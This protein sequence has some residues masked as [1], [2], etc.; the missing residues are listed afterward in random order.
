MELSRRRIQG[1]ISQKQGTSTVIN[2]EGG[3]VTLGPLLTSL[4]AEAMP[5]AEGYLHWTGSAWEWNSVVAESYNSTTAVR[6]KSEI[7]SSTH[8]T[9]DADSFASGISLVQNYYTVGA[10]TNAPTGMS[11]GCVLQLRSHNGN[12]DGQLA[13]DINHDVTADVTRNLWWRARNSTGWEDSWKRIAFADELANYATVGSLNS[14]LP[15]AGGNMSGDIEFDE[16][17]GLTFNTNNYIDCTRTFN[18]I[19]ITGQDGVKLCCGNNEVI[20]VLSTQ[21]TVSGKLLVTGTS[22]SSVTIEN[23]SVTAAY[24]KFNDNNQYPSTIATATVQINSVN[25]PIVKYLVKAGGLHYF[26]KV[27]TGGEELAEIC[28][29]EMQLE[30]GAQKAA[31][32]LDN[33]HVYARNSNGQSQMII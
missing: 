18:G 28:C 10:I 3:G 2:Q 26:K 6:A 12:L 5:S 17:F 29:K 19:I 13:W 21:T 1:M 4:N 11:Y 23:G 20:A 33:G 30:S 16:G 31:I 22:N 15:L 9:Q 7:L 25:T 8:T 32:Y 14:Y 27:V 24:L